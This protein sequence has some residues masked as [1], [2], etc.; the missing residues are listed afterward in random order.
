M[1]LCV[2]VY[3]YIYIYTHTYTY[4]YAYDVKPQSCHC[5]APRR[6]AEGCSRELAKV[7]T[8]RKITYCT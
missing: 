3:V 5:L 7:K 4:T 1:C 2:Y 6:G 8:P